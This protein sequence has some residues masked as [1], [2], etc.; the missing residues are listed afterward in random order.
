MSSVNNDAHS[1]LP[2]NAIE[3][4][5]SRLARDIH[6]G[7]AQYLVH[8]L[9]KL[10]LIQHLL[11][12]LPLHPSELAP[13]QAELTHTT[14]SVELCLVELRQQITTL[15]PPQLQQHDL[16]T[17]IYTFFAEMRLNTPKLAIHAD[18]AP[19]ATLPMVLHKPLFRLIQEALHNITRHAHATDISLT[20][21]I[22]AGLL[23]LEVSDNGIGISL[24]SREKE[25]DTSQHVGLRFMRERVEELGGTWVLQSVLEK[26]TT[27]RVTIPLK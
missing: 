3:Q 22:D 13:I 19:L 26:G 17:A 18:I 16:T 10:A 6:D 15:L 23:F 7:A 5:R 8:V 2:A 20:I 27:V 4:E 14:S 9:H 11:T 21:N 24:P 12:E 1:N 25:H